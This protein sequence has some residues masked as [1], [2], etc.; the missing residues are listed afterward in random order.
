VGMGF[1]GPVGEPRQ[2]DFV[3]PAVG[4]VGDLM[5]QAYVAA[6]IMI[7]SYVAAHPRDMAE[8]QEWMSDRVAS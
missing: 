8:W 2:H 5:V 1:S 4:R 6:P 7:P 3:H